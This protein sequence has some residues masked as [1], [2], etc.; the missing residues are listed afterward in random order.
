M[1]APSWIAVD[2]M[3]GDKGLSVM[4]AGVAQA[5]RRFEDFRFL[6]VGD[7]A[8]IREGLSAHPGLTANAEIVHAPDRVGDDRRAVEHQSHRAGR[9]TA[10]S[11]PIARLAMRFVAHAPP[12]WAWRSTW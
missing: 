12:R 7:E 8:A 5:R 10:P 11:Y 9:S 1:T 3:G 4:L 2:A 6:L